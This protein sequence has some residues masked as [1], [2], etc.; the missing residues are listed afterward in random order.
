MAGLSEV[1]IFQVDRRILLIW[2]LMLP[3]LGTLQYKLEVVTTRG[4]RFYYLIIA[5]SL[6]LSSSTRVQEDQMIITQMTEVAAAIIP[7][8]TKTICA[9]LRIELRKLSPASRAFK[10]LCKYSNS[11]YRT[12]TAFNKDY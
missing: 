8:Q 2:S 4:S 12:L 5:T 3:T 11:A 7:L 1:E 10:R 9:G 6:I